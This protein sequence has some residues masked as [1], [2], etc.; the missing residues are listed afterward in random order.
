[1]SGR[2]RPG[3]R[4]ADADCSRVSTR[5]ESQTE[6]RKRD[7]GSGK[8]GFGAEWA[9]RDLVSARGWGRTEPPCEPPG[10]RCALSDATRRVAASDMTQMRCL[11]VGEARRFVTSRADNN[12]GQGCWPAGLI[13]REFCRPLRSCAERLFLGRAEKP[14]LSS[15]ETTAPLLACAQAE[16]RARGGRTRRSTAIDGEAQEV[17][18]RQAEG[19]LRGLQPLPAPQGETQLR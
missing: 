2:K 5:P 17:P 6:R 4:G 3:L 8:Q 7:D 10:A 9:G 13:A 12:A 14:R 1:M 16:A 11:G 15:R 18:A 19:R